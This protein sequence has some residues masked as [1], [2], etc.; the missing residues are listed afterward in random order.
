MLR[1]ESTKLWRPDAPEVS[2]PSAKTFD[3]AVG[4]D[5]D[6]PAAEVARRGVAAG[7]DRDQRVV[8][9]VVRQARISS[10]M[11][12]GPEPWTGTRT[13]TPAGM[14][15]AASATEV[16]V[17]DRPVARSADEQAAGVDRGVRHREGR[18]RSRP[19]VAG[20]MSSRSA[21]RSAR[22]SRTGRRRCP[23]TG[24]IAAVDGRRSGRRSGVRRPWSG[25]SDADQELA[26]EPLH[27]A[28]ARPRRD[29]ARG[30]RAEVGEGRVDRRGV[31]GVRAVRPTMRPEDQPGLSD[32]R[33]QRRRC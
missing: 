19:L 33:G 29:A 7:D 32:A 26:V 20:R 5:P 31:V 9:R 21:S 4:R 27:A 6:D 23:R 10:W 25:S 24:G 2:K 8:H 11:P 17:T 13:V 18:G 30:G 12:T 1:L 3:D 16:T 28:E 15:A 14:P 22:S